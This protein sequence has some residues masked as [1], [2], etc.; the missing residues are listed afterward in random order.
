[1]SWIWHWWGKQY[2]K[3]SV[4]VL[5]L[6]YHCDCVFWYACITDTNLLRHGYVGGWNMKWAPVFS[7]HGQ[8]TDVSNQWHWL[9]QTWNW[10]TCCSDKKFQ[11]NLFIFILWSA[12]LHFHTPTTHTTEPHTPETEIPTTLF[13]IVII[14]FYFC[15]IR[16]LFLQILIVTDYK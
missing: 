15:G 1:M 6:W 11:S 4:K 2:F 3:L 12:C 10:G 14:L 8:Y 5:N 7:N 13:H 9:S 16:R